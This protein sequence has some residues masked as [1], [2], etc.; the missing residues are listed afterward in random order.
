M[1]ATGIVRRIDDLGRVV[2]PKEIRRSLKIREGDALEIF[3]EDDGVIFK[4]YS[5]LGIVKDTAKHLCSAALASH[6]MRIAI[7]DR[8]TIIASGE[9]LSKESCEVSIQA[10]DIMNSR[11]SCGY[12]GSHPMYLDTY[13]K[14]QVSLIDPIISDGDVVGAVAVLGSNVDTDE[15]Q[16]KVARNISLFLGKYMST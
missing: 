4:K 16:F 15:S 2:I 14:I 3:L 7:T 12:D 9:R 8:D 1:K 13:E 10:R 5:H 11:R 6:G